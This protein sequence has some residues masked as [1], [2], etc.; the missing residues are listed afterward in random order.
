MCLVQVNGYK[1]FPWIHQRCNN[2][3]Y[4]D[5]TRAVCFPDVDPCQ[6]PKVTH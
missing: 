2:M 1:I 5:Q 6:L 4:E 3:A